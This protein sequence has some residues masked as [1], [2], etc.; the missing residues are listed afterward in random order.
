MDT[1]A[2]DD[3]D[4]VIDVGANIGE[5]SK[6]L[7][8]DRSLRI[9]AIEPEQLEFVSLQKNLEG[10]DAETFNC[11]LWSCSADL[12]FYSANDTGD[13]SVFKPRN[14][15]EP[16]PRKAMA[17]DELASCSKILSGDGPIKLL[18]LEAEG[19][20]PEILEGASRIL[21]RIEYIAADV[22]PERGLSKES[23]LIPVQTILMDYG[24]VPVKFGLPR[25]VMLFKRN[26][27]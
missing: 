13:S 9:V 6:G 19:A 10:S 14:N 3:E 1:I 22:G 23:T 7:S 4:I 24:F 16:S 2:F 18:K 8:M 12:D 17:L 21:Q 26:S 20:E 27:M 11:L 5:L 15:I 25:A